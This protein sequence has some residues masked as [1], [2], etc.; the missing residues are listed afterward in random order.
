M[1]QRLREKENNKW[2]YNQPKQT[3]NP[4]ALTFINVAVSDKDLT[5]TAGDDVF[6]VI[7]YRNDLRFMII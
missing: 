1:P 6:C 3:K 4:E 7:I 5:H 2:Q